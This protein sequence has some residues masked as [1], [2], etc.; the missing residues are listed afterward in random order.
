MFLRFIGCSLSAWIGHG[1][2]DGSRDERLAFGVY[3]L[4]SHFVLSV[5]LADEDD[6]VAAAVV[7]PLPGQVV[8][9]DVQVPDSRRD[10]A[11]GRSAD[12]NDAKVL[13]AVRNE[14]DAPGERSGKRRQ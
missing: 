4:D 10:V 8:E 7:R 2:R 1:E 9:R 14:D 3:R 5:R 12:G 11:G 13:Q 6:R